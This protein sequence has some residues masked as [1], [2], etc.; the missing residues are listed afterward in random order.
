[1]D[2][3]ELWKSHYLLTL[4]ILCFKAENNMDAESVKLLAMKRSEMQMFCLSYSAVKILVGFGIFDATILAYL[5]FRYMGAK[6][7]WHM[8]RT[9]VKI[10][11]RWLCL[12]L[13]LL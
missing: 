1:M 10:T 12:D 13:N 6:I 11:F 4:M 2:S 3:D 5:D 7:A 9:L 8:A